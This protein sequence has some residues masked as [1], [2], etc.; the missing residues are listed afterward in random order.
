[1]IHPVSLIYKEYL[2]EVKKECDISI[3][4]ENIFAPLDNLMSSVLKDEI[5]YELNMRIW[6][7]VYAFSHVCQVTAECKRLLKLM[8]NNDYT[9]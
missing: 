8:V 6:N 7:E 3:I 9:D 5:V 4:R 1:M 2:P